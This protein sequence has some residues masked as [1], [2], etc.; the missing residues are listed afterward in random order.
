MNT[1]ILSESNPDKYD[2]CTFNL[3][4]P[5]FDNLDD[6]LIKQVYGI[7]IN[8]KNQ[9]ILC[10]HY[11]GMVLLPGGKRE[12]SDNGSLITT[13][14]REA[15]E[16]GNVVLDEDTITEAFYQSVEIDGKVDSYQVR[17]IARTKQV[18]E[19]ESDPDGGIVSV[20]WV[21]IEDLDK[22]LGWGKTDAVIMDIARK[23]VLEN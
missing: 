6:S 11:N 20:C 2:G 18:T 3:Y 13:L 15:L 19:F 1:L 4:T 17:Y 10:N 12:L 7:I 14:N 22:H 9:I 21:D 5:P 8:D 23:Y 16:E